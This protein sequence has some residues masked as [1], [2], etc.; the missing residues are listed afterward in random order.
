MTKI[1]KL[2]LIAAVMLTAC[3][4]KNPLKDENGDG[5]PIIKIDLPKFDAVYMFD[6]QYLSGAEFSGQELTVHFSGMRSG[7][8][9]DDLGR[10]NNNTYTVSTGFL[11]VNLNPN[12]K[13]DGNRT[14]SFTVS[15]SSPAGVVL[16][17]VVTDKTGGIRGIDV[18]VVEYSEQK[19]GGSRNIDDVEIEVRGTQGELVAPVARLG[20]EQRGDG[21]RYLDLYQA[22]EDGI[23]ICGDAGEQWES[24]GLFALSERIAT[25]PVKMIRLRAGEYFTTIA[26][27][28]G[29][30]ATSIEINLDSPN[31]GTA[32]SVGYTVETAD[33]S[34]YKGTITGATPLRGRIEQ[35]YV[36]EADRGAKVRLHPQPIFSVTPSVAEVADA[37]APSAA[38]SFEVGPV[39]GMNLTRYDINLTA[40]CAT[41]R[42]IAVAATKMFQYSKVDPTAPQDREW[43]TAVMESGRSSV[44]MSRGSIYDFRVSFNNKWESYMI[45]TDPSKIEEI[46]NDQHV[47]RYTMND[48]GDRV[49]IDI[50]VTHEEICNF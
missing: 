36:E 34:L 33:G 4:I 46:L 3:N 44:Y 8:L 9:I 7:D 38:V 14:V 13:L 10:I 18:T 20:V 42:Q 35:I 21:Y 12:I 22:T 47:L 31:S 30:L 16:P 26:R 11:S 43:I 32:I 41:D 29:S 49:T 1:S 5:I 45:T 6:F 37:T 27:K 19:R 15:G 2:L 28:R 48:E 39:S 40:V 23:Y 25:E 17:R 50:E 24:Y